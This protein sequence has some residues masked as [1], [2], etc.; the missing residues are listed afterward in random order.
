MQIGWKGIDYSPRPGRY[1]FID[2]VLIVEPRHIEIWNK[3]PDA[4][5]AVVVSLSESGKH[6]VLGDY[7]REPAPT[8]DAWQSRHQRPADMPQARQRSQEQAARGLR[9]YNHDF[10]LARAPR[11]AGLVLAIISATVFS[12]NS[13]SRLL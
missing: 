11:A 7:H 5:F 9:V 3:H 6:Y 12:R 2:S 4:I 1:H 8:G 10:D 13:G